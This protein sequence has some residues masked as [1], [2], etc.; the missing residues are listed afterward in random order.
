MKCIL[1][2]SNLP[3][4]VHMYFDLELSTVDIA[5]KYNCSDQTIG[6]FLTKNGYMLRTINQSV[7]TETV[8]HKI[9]KHT[10]KNWEDDNFRN[11]QISKRKGKPSGASGKT[12]RVTTGRIYE[13]KGEKNPMWQGG[14]TKLSFAIKNLKEYKEWRENVFKRDNYT[15]QCCGRRSKVGDKVFLECHHLKPFSKIL[16]D[17]NILNL[18]DALKYE[19]LFDIDNGQTL[20]K[21]CHKNTD[22][23]G[24]NAKYVS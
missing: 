6:R 13:I 11:N 24:V 7:K 4:I 10:S 5:K 9:S 3:D 23:Y 14:I 15:C 8:K 2:E 19:E 21:K 1:N 18:E 12:W 16:K 17:N 20:C 22:T